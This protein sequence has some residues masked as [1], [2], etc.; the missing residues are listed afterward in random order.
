MCGIVFSSNAE[1]AAV[2]QLIAAVQPRGPDYAH[3]LN[4]ENLAFHASVL[5]LRGNQIAQQPFENDRGILVY[6]S[7]VSSHETKLT[8]PQNGEIFDGL[9]VTTEQNDGQRL[10]AAL[11]TTDPLIVLREAKGPYALAY[12]DKATQNLYYARDP[13]GRRSL[14]LCQDG[15]SWLLSSV[16]PAALQDT[17][18]TEVP[19]DAV[20]RLDL[21]TNSVTPHTRAHLSAAIG[22]NQQRYPFDRLKD[23]IP[24]SA[25]RLQACGDG[26]QLTAKSAAAIDALRCERSHGVNAP[27]DTYVRRA[28]DIYAQASRGYSS[29]EWARLA[30]EA[31]F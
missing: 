3:T 6:V 1:H 22:A 14:L 24:A 28:R 17:S 12:F 8:I 11:T 20:F 15:S 7:R 5:H 26:L 31:A 2:P 16:V 9:D 21:S 10:F 19:C 25:D 18:W 27:A 23:R 13:I 29:L 4:H 30:T